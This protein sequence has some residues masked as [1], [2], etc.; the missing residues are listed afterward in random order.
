M[1]RRNF[2]NGVGAGAI[3]ALAVTN[4]TVVARDA[5]AQT[6][7]NPDS[8]PDLS[9]QRQRLERF[10]DQYLEAVVANDPGLCPLADNVIFVENQQQLPI[11]DAGWRTINRIGSY[12]HFFAD[13]EMDQVGLIANVY[14]H[15]AG[16]VF[17]LRLKIENDKIAQIDQ[18][19][20]R[21]PN[22]AE[23]YEKLG[24]PDPIWLEPIPMAQRQ[25]REALEMSAFMY[26]EAL[27]RN[28]GT[29]IY[30]FRPDCE[31]IEHARRTVSQE[32]NSGYGHADAATKFVTLPA[33]KQYE[34]GMMAFVTRIRDRLAP[35]IDIERGAVFGQGTYDFDGALTKIHFIEDDNDWVIPPYFRTARSHMAT[36]GFKVINGSFRY[37]EMTF[38]EVPFG[39]RQHW[40]GR[41]MTV[42]LEY[43]P[44]RPKPRPIKSATYK[45]LVALNQLVLDAIINDCPC[46]LPLADDVRYTENGVLVEP[47][48]GGLWKT[49][50]G[51]REYSVNLADPATQQAAWFGTL[52][53]NTLFAAVAMRIQVRDGYISNI[54]TIIAR[55]E[56]Y[57]RR[58]ELSGATNTM[59]VPP[60]LADLDQDAFDAVPA[61]LKRSSKGT[62][63][64]II[65]AIE[66]YIKAVAQRDA[67]LA[68]F[69]SD[70]MRRENGIDAC[71]NPAGPQINEARSDLRFYAGDLVTEINRG[72]LSQL[73]AMREHKIWVVDE[74]QG[75]ALDLTVFDN[76]AA[77]TMVNLEGEGAVT[78]PTSFLISWTD[79]HAQLYKV[80]R[81]KIAHMEDIVRRVT[82]GQQLA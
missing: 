23:N 74:K 73:T 8:A 48:S 17:V 27:E 77:S 9:K 62:R 59:Y 2:L 60:L 78:V 25:S 58:G 5:T 10:V 30:P 28:D 51:I 67:S 56:A 7:A 14:E 22:G 29:G 35:V 46:T 50:K 41:P 72:Y 11:G 43:E 44:V 75:L 63:R 79:L 4:G 47:G 76:N 65:Q 49:V 31:R 24:A 40:L 82:Y 68:N 18:W 34:F 80:E 20:S 26:F 32:D 3:G 61:V 45:S 52:N 36:E 54:D 13:M 42:D 70:C 16:C 38:L 33:K 6:N 15:D 1:K 81:G 19:I 64:D 37:V 53:E 69:N 21:D 71:N 39:T 12:K 55:P 66:N 57:G